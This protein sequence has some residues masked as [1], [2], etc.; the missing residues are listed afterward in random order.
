MRMYLSGLGGAQKF[1]IQWVVDN[2]PV[3]RAL[4]SYAYLGQVDK[5]LEY[6][7][8]SL[9]LDSGAFTAYASGI[10]IV[11]D[12][13]IAWAK[14]R[15]DLFE[16]ITNLD[17]IGDWEGSV[18]NFDYARKKGLDVWPVYHFGEPVD[19]LHYYMSVTDE[20]CVGGIASGTVNPDAIKRGLAWLFNLYPDM[21]LHVLGV[22][23]VNALI[24]FPI[25][26]CDAL[27]WRSG[28]RFGDVFIKGRRHKVGRKF[29][30]SSRSKEAISVLQ[31]AGLDVTDPDFDWNLLDCYNISILYQMLE[32]DHDAMDFNEVVNTNFLF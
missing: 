26:S 2:V 16:I 25:F 6:D 30:F 13:Y 12:D 10:E 21:K 1:I 28:S 22:N 17:V 19:V 4:V 32:V 15:K 20:M 14:E 3:P 11:H 9:Y 29:Q 18:K 24:Q 27:T 31:E 8:K 23:A 7:L 5:L